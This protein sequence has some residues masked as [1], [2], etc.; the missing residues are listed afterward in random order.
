MY[1]SQEHFSQTPPLSGKNIYRAQKVKSIPLESCVSD[2]I[3]FY[4]YN[5]SSHFLLLFVYNICCLP[6][7]IPDLHPF[8]CRKCSLAAQRF[9]LKNLIKIRFAFMPVIFCDLKQ[10][11]MKVLASPRLNNTSLFILK[12]HFLNSL[13]W[14]PV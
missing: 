5:F 12:H 10:E 6:A 8:N 1:L 2:F 11:S 3:M 4:T 14:C 7:Q 9:H 13:G